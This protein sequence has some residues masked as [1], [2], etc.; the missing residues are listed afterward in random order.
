MKI[1]FDLDDTLTD[2]EGYAKEFCENYLKANNIPYKVQKTDT[3]MLTEMFDWTKEQFDEFWTKEGVNYLNGAPARRG[4]KEVLEHLQKDGHE[5]YVITQRYW[6]DAYGVAKA[7]LDKNNVPFNKLVVNA[8]DKLAA[9]KEHNVDVYLDD[10]IKY[11]DN[12]NQNGVTGIVMNTYFN[13]SETTEAKRVDSLKEFYRFIKRLEF[14]K[15][16]ESVK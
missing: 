5:V 8:K 2:N 7:W 14:E 3:M 6:G 10:R 4:A 12:L 9:C 13:K 16:E 15:S 1:G 11:I